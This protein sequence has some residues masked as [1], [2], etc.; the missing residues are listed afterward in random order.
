MFDRTAENTAGET[1]LLGVNRPYV[2]IIW[3][4]VFLLGFADIIAFALA[5]WLFRVGRPVPQL[6]F[7]PTNVSHQTPVDLIVPLA[8]VF[9]F[10]RYIAGDYSRRRLFWDNARSTTLALL[11]TSLPCVIINILLPEQFSGIA[12]LN[13]WV[14]LLFAVPFLRQAARVGMRYVGL[15]QLPTVM[16]ADSERARDLYNAIKSTT[17]LGYDI[18]WVVAEHADCNIPRG[19]ENDPKRLSATEAGQLASRLAAEG[20][21]RAVISTDDMQSADFA[22]LI[23]RFMEVGINV[24][25]SPSFRRLP[26]VGVTTSYFFGRDLLLFQMRSSLQR[27]PQRLAKRAFDIVMSAFGLIV[28]SPVFLAIAALIKLKYPS[29]PVF[30]G[31][32][33]EGR[34]GHSFLM[35]K[36]STMV[37]NA[38]LVLDKLLAENEALRREWEETFK[39]K[40]DPR[41]L[42]GIGNFLRRTS[43]NELPQLVNVLVGEMS[44]V[45]PRPVK[46]CELI[47][48]Y[49]SAAQLYRRIRPGITGL[50][51]VR[52]RSDTTYE[53]RVV[54]DEWYILNWSFWYDIVILLQTVWSV[55]S[56]K[57]AY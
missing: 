14:F 8:C 5:Y 18:R 3:L 12:E 20:C 40:D 39:L 53:E 35:W 6:V 1:A 49:G 9:V 41:I 51:Q 54:Y 26:V 21:E 33:V 16:I 29:A 10:V 31:Q 45:G 13:T 2:A 7:F 30:F 4:R 50:W 44:L 47:Q 11:V 38:H 43:L 52:G 57:G 56:G 25:F 22:G 15:W 55:L 37:P 36:F 28:L 24:S 32:K 34:G 46:T 27:T 48:Y 23:Q 17:S 19:G 42:P